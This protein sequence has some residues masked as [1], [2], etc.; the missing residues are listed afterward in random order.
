MTARRDS[1][2]GDGGGGYDHTAIFSLSSRVRRPRTSWGVRQNPPSPR[3][4][5]AAAGSPALYIENGRS[6]DNGAFLKPTP[7]LE[8]GTPS[9]RAL[10]RMLKESER[11]G[12][13][14]TSASS[15]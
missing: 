6:S 15:G 1:D 10:F 7:G 11:R 13:S 3:S 5:P 2:D 8:P 9:L 14:A 4:P 12:R